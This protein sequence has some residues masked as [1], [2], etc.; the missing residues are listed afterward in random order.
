MILLLFMLFYCL[1]I[2]LTTNEPSL[3][4]ILLTVE[5]EVR[6]GRGM[7]GAWEGHITTCIRTC[8]ADSNVRTW[9]ALVIQNSL[10][11][12]SEPLART[13]FGGGLDAPGSVLQHETYNQ[14]RLN[15]CAVEQIV[16]MLW[17]MYK[18]N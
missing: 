2:D 1:P 7:G 6:A 16:P 3:T 18:L 10:S 17:C 8:T 14:F 12:S 11:I 5:A 9:L 15:W 4:R 13:M